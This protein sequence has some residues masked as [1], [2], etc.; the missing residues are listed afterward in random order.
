MHANVIP[1]ALAIIWGGGGLCSL[2]SGRSRVKSKSW[3]VRKIHKKIHFFR[4]RAWGRSPSQP[5]TVA[6]WLPPQPASGVLPLPSFLDHWHIN[7][8]I[9]RCC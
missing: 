4:G 9:L 5:D 3:K 7:Y 8:R 1:R 6:S 2:G